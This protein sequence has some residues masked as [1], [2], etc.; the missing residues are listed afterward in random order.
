MLRHAFITAYLLFF[1]FIFRTYIVGI[2]N[3]Y[4]ILQGLGKKGSLMIDRYTQPAM[5]HIFSLENKY[6]VWKEI[7]VCACE[8]QAELG[9]IGITKDEAAWIRAHA[10]CNKEEIDAL[11]AQVNHDVIAFLTNMASYIDK[12]VP[13][14][15]PHP[16]R[17]V[18]FGMT[19]TDLGDTALCYMLSQALD[20]LKDDVARL[21]EICKRRAFEEK[22]TLCVGR[23]HGIHAEPMTFGM[24]FASWA[25]ELK[26]DLDRLNNAQ[27]S[28]S[29]GAISGAVGTYSSID[30]RVEQ[31]VCEKLHLKVDPLSTQVISRD[32]HAYVASVLAVCAATCERIATEIRGLQKTDTLE[33]EEP[34]KK[35][36]KGSSAMPHKRNPITAEKVCGLAR[37]VKANAQVAYD[38]VALWHERDISHS[39]NERVA[40]ADSFIALDHMFTCLI[41]IVDGLVLYPKR[42]LAN[43]NKTRGLIYSSKVLLALVDTGMTREDAYL[44]VQSC[45]MKTWKE[46]QECERGTSFKE[47]LKA[48]P[49]C[50]LSDD[51]LDTIFDPQQFLTHTSIVFD[52][53]QALDFACAC[54]EKINGE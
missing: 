50:V 17:W 21:G 32:H 43:L 45:A 16:S 1:V 5:G 23:T 15:A 49:A 33:V 34:F 20:I 46:I 18:H 40:L 47:K 9:L 10:A 37:V 41:R 13:A 19:S 31:M 36:Q 14:E 52:R 53:L 42:M 22:S 6:N 38:N 29:Y 3:T 54:H 26:R 25:Q 8:A 12:D 27:E 35:K 4:I 48:D 30:P 28:V 7:E 51:E 2:L 39:S 44:I 11:E 24:K